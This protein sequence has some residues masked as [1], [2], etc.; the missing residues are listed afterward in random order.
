MNI[1]DI[2]KVQKLSGEFDYSLIKFIIENTDVAGN[3]IQNATKKAKRIE[4]EVDFED[5]SSSGIMILETAQ[6]LKKLGVISN[7]NFESIVKWLKNDANCGAATSTSIINSFSCAISSAIKSGALNVTKQ[8][9]PPYYDSNGQ[10]VFVARDDMLELRDCLSYKDKKER[11]VRMYAAGARVL[12]DY[13]EKILAAAVKSFLKKF[14][15]DSETNI[16]DILDLICEDDKTDD[17][18]EKLL[19]KL[20]SILDDFHETPVTK[21]NWSEFL[22]TQN[23]IVVISTGYDSI[24]KGTQA[25]DMLLENLYAFKQRYP[26]KRYTVIA[27]PI[28]Y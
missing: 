21:N 25:I 13:Q 14:R 10:T 26:D 16:C 15:S 3:L 1:D 12:G 23:P 17:A 4:N 27:P 24:G 28:N 19:Y 11:L 7:S 22:D 20:D 9:G 8:F 18:H 2:R 6:F 5:E